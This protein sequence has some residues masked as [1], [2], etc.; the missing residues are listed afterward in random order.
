M[1]KLE[2]DLRQVAEEILEYDYDHNCW[3]LIEEEWNGH[4]FRFEGECRSHE[5]GGG[6]MYLDGS[7]VG[8][9]Q[10]ECVIEGIEVQDLELWDDE[11]EEWVAF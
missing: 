1:K 3:H 5:K 6:S 11:K 8:D 2:K 7:P 9:Y 10:S 4:L